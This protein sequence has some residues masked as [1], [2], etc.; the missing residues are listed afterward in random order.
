MTYAEQLAIIKDIPIR[1]G[2]SKV[3]QCPFC[4]GVK[5]LAI[6][7]HD[8]KTLWNCYR[9]SCNGKGIYSGKRDVR[10]VK[11]YLAKAILEKHSRFRPVPSIT[12]SVYNAPRAVDFLNSVNSLEAFEKDYINVRYSPAEDRVV[13]YTKTG[14][15]GRTLSGIGPKWVSYGDLPS[16]IHVGEG[17]TAILVEDVPSACSISRLS[18]YVGVA[19]LGTTITSGIKL[20]LSNYTKI[21]LVLDKDASL[22]SIAQTR[23]INR[24]IKIRLTNIDLKE[25]TAD[26]IQ[27]LI[28]LSA[29]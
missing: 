25:M 9:A 7:K 3:I 12:T 23:K 14:A 19:L 6:S 2:D 5:K 20:A 29:N 4:Y 21:Y 17:S 22:K 1:E 16:G 28:N 18:G 10:A 11:N 26:Q 8:G 27:Q 24:N 15:V 13:F